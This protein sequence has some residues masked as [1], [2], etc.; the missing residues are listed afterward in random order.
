MNNGFWSRVRRFVND[1]LANRIMSDQKFVIYGKKMY[2]FISYTP[3]YVLN[4]QFH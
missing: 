1:S 2:H 4:T 3:F